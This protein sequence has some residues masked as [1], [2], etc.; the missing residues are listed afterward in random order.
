[1]TSKHYKKQRYKR[2][3]IIKKYLNNDGHIVDGFIVD[4]GHPMGAECHSIT[5]NGVI[6]IHN[7]E[8]GKLITK[9]VAREGQIKRYYEHTDRERPQEYEHILYLTR[10]HESLGY[11]CI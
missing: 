10:W 1:M 5:D 11:N 3:R 4:R 2:E 8:S 7:I 9:L 6:V